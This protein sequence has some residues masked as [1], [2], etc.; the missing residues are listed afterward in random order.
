MLASGFHEIEDIVDDFFP[1]HSQA[2]IQAIKADHEGRRAEGAE[3][4][5]DAPRTLDEHIL[6][7]EA[8]LRPT[9]RMLRWL[10]HVGAQAIAALWSDMQAPRTPGQTTDWLEVA[11]GR[12]EAW[13]GSSAQAGARRALEFVKAWYP[14]LDL[15][16]LAT[17][18]SEAQPELAATEDALVK[19][20]VAIAEYTDTSIFIPERSED[21]EEV[22]PEWFGMNPD[23]GED[24]AEVI[25]SSVEEEGEAE[26]GG[27]TE[28]PEDGADGQPQLDRA[29]SNEPCATKPTA[30]RGNQ[31]KTAQ[32]A[33]PTPGAA[34]S[35]DPPNPSAAS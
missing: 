30:A 10:Q 29:S 23:Y 20:A 19:R 15:D 7:I 5:A 34:A 1:G 26:D 4:T 12:L 3:I 27:D 9:H 25:G 13:T 17:L 24:S 14:G 28:A 18:R 35:F 21:G 6:S 8:R 16:Q 32:P 33:A 31:A 22:P 2:A 11:A